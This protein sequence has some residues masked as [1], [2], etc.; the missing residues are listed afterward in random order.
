MKA[1]DRKRISRAIDSELS[2]HERQQLETLRERNPQPVE[3]LETAYLRTGDLAR[4]DAPAKTPDPQEAWF[5]IRRTMRQ[6]E[7]APAR[8]RRSPN[9]AR[10]TALSFAV[11]LVM[12]GGIYIAASQRLWTW[13]EQT[14]QSGPVSVSRVFS[15]E[16]A[17]KG[18]TTMIFED[19]EVGLTV[20]WIDT[21]EE[22]G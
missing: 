3:D 22:E 20:V 13:Y 1:K 15:V 16:T 18:A 8:A 5:E 2:P 7:P 10:R 19:E 17:I 4:E 9:L 11:I 6:A 21:P 14:V 12:I